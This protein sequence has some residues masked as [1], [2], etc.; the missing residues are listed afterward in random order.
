MSVNPFTKRSVKKSSPVFRKLED[1]GWVEESYEKGSLN[2]LVTT[3]KISLKCH[4][5][6]VVEHFRKNR[7]LIA[8]HSLGSGKT[9][10]SIAA[11]MEYLKKDLE[12]RKVIVLSP[13]SL[14]DNFRKE[15]ISYLDD[16]TLIN[17]YIIMSYD[18]FSR[19][20][21][22]YKDMK[23]YFLIVDEAHNLRT[24]IGANSGTKAKRVLEFA[25]KADKVLLLTATPFY[26]DPHDIANLVAMADNTKGIPSKDFFRV[27]IAS[28][29]SRVY[30]E[31]YFK[32]IISVYT[33][34]KTSLRDNYPSHEVNQVYLKMPPKYLEIYRLL[35]VNSS[36]TEMYYRNPNL[37]Y[38]GLRQASN[39]IDD[40]MVSPKI[41]WVQ[42]FLE[43]HSGEKTLIF[44]N[45]IQAGI[46][47]IKQAAP[48]DSF[49]VI[50][51]KT[52]KSERQKIVKEYNENKDKNILIITR[53]GGEGLDLKN[54]RN[55]IILDPS[56]NNSV[57]DQV[58]GRAIR[59]Q[60][61]ISLPLEER[62]VNI[63]QLFL[64]KP[65]EHYAF[66]NNTAQRYS[67][68]AYRS[69]QTEKWSVDL[70]LKL[71]SKE[72]DQ[73]LKGFIKEKV[74]PNSIEMN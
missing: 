35:E 36:T 63:Y 5:E 58:M 32:N 13:A 8:I 39:K 68:L 50:E 49:L 48:S 46:K 26:N 1:D 34:D 45:W 53:A 16:I 42:K 65:I 74:L 73:Y 3:S 17:N 62:H 33:P 52:T 30:F 29:K 67:K 72:K 21:D 22:V 47:Y 59:Y 11:S 31:K 4:Q 51:G 23:D 2:K 37:F 55:V 71:L 43:I 15:L 69:T 7:G 20:Y 27:M 70:Y 40:S 6:K 56:W 25:R 24:K 60:S 19:N 12:K 57:D 28:D 61:H 41:E 64:L 14:E 18:K 10:T 44:S 66:M 54:T 38:N 9:F